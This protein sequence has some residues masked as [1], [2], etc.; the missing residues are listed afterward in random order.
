MASMPVGIWANLVK[1]DLDQY[2]QNR[3]GM[4]AGPPNNHGPMDDEDTESWAPNNL[5]TLTSFGRR[6]SSTAGSL[7][8]NSNMT[9]S[10]ADI[11]YFQTEDDRKAAVISGERMIAAL[12]VNPVITFVKPAPDQ[13]VA[14][15]VN[16]VVPLGFQPDVSYQQNV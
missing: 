8:I 1:S 14:D 5:L 11:P 7:A 16:S 12:K 10:Y 6:G 2:L 4:L 3:S 13:T 9:M 15:Y